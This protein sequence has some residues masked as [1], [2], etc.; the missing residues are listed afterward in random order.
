MMPEASHSRKKLSTLTAPGQRCLLLGAKGAGMK[1]LAEILADLR[2]DV[3]G[4]DKCATAEDALKSNHPSMSLQPWKDDICL[5]GID[6]CIASPAIA[7]DEPLIQALRS[8]NVPISSLHECLADIFSTTQQICVAGTHGKSTTSAM[9][10]W[11]LDF[12]GQKPG[13]F[14]GAHQINLARSGRAP[15]KAIGIQ[16]AASPDPTA[17]W[18]VLESCEYSRSFRHF[19]PATVVLT[20]IERDHFDCFP[21]QHSE[22]SAFR[23]FVQQLPAEGTIVFDTACDRSR[24]IAEASGRR[25]ATFEVFADSGMNVNADLQAS[26]TNH[27]SAQQIQHSGCS[28]TFQL[29]NNGKR[30]PVRLAIPGIHNVANATAAIVAAVNAGI[31]VE[32][33][34]RALAEFRGIRRRFE[35]RGH[36][37]GMTLIDDY[38]HHP[39]AIRAA[40]QTARTSFPG[41]RIVAAFEPHQMV[42]TAALFPE[43]VNSLQLADEILLLPVFPARETVTHLECCRMSGKLVRELNNLG[44]RAF[45][46]ANLD[47]IV[48]RIDHSGRP[49]D[50]I[51]TMGAGRT[52]LIHDQLTR[53]LQR[54]SVA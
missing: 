5:N 43:F 42:R 40:L 10:A 3:I 13:C 15:A 35:F 24:Q 17:L 29:H 33:C 18:S 41:R 46:F 27:W 1:A 32:L 9:I 38:A 21:D 31:S 20:G 37:D 28:T 2:H 14:V 30:T 52:N 8:A 49:T 12:A 7:N 39:S 50:I 34:C 36:Y 22:D 45:L 26:T 6:L 54:H 47:Q 44:T 11:I 25:L 48:S 16:T 51:L 4:V 19:Q 23:E 53:R